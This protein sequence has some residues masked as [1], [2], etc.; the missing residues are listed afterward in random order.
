MRFRRATK[1]TT[2]GV[3]GRAQVLEMSQT[4]MFVNNRA[5]I[6]LRVRIEAPGIPPYENEESVIVPVIALSAL[7]PGRILPV[8]VDPGNPQNF[9]INWRGSTGG[10]SLPVDAEAE[11][12]GESGPTDED[13]DLAESPRPGRHGAA[14]MPDSGPLSSSDH[15]DGYEL[16]AGQRLSK[17]VALRNAGQ[18]SYEEFEEHKRRI[19]F[20]I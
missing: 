3:P 10:A 11:G 12:E 6:Q 5:R 4:G 2:T 14:A 19:L 16:D 9:E 8:L 17:L 15:P 20:D 1:L 13:P 7:Q 18:I